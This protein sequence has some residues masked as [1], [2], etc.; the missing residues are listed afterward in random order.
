M[1]FS[2]DTSKKEKNEKTGTVKNRNYHGYATKILS[3]TVKKARA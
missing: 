3:K 2:R 1:F